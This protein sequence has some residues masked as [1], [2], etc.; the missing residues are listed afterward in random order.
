MPKRP[1][2]PISDKVNV[3][4]RLTQAMLDELRRETIRTGHSRTALL[5]IAWAEYMQRVAEKPRL[6]R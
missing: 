5:R 4:I 2:Q 3:H 6:R 1:E